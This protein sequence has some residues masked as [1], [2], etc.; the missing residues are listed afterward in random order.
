MSAAYIISRRLDPLFAISIGAM[1]TA[2]RISREEKEKGRTT[3]ETI[4]VLRR[5]AGMAWGSI[6]S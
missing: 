6:V 4:Q 3:S 2:A 1:A 5:R